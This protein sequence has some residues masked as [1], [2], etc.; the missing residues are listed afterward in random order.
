MNMIM[1]SNIFN[2]IAMTVQQLIL[3][4]ITLHEIIQVSK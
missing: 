3:W 2:E 4:D 1:M